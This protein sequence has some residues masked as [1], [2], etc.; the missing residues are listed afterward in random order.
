V[1]EGDKVI[2]RWLLR[3]E[4]RHV[5]DAALRAWLDVNSH[6]PLGYLW[7]DVP[8][9]ARRIHRALLRLQANLETM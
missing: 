1:A 7:A 9:S 6:L 3:R 4:A 2:R 8:L 5:A